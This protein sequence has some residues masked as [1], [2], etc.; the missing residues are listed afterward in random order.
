MIVFWVYAVTDRIR[1]VLTSLG[2]LLKTW[3]TEQ[4]IYNWQ[5]V[6]KF[7]KIVM[8][9]LQVQKPRFIGA[10]SYAIGFSIAI[11]TTLM[12]VQITI[13]DTL[14]SKLDITEI[15]KVMLCRKIS[16]TKMSTNRMPL[17][18]EVNSEC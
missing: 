2:A 4:A 17:T 10:I 13:I 5:G 8:V 15:R 14:D 11:M 3:T 1:T 18:E 9:S 6:F 7:L 16:S 12:K